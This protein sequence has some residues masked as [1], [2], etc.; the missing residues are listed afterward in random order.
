MTNEVEPLADAVPV[1]AARLNICVSM[2]YREAA[3]GRLVVRKLGR[4]SLVERAAQ[5]AWLT[6]LP[7][8]GRSEATVA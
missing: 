8:M 3:A 2:L 4:R 6:A 5:Q 7:V 1:A